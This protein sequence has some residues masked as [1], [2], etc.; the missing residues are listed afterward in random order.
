M[1]GSLVAA[2]DMVS[3]TA[4]DGR[5]GCRCGPGSEDAAYRN[6]SQPPTRKEYQLMSLIDIRY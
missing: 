3:S 4:G 1:P 6:G 2:P 5:D